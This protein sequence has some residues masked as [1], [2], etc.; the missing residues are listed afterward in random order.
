MKR[1]ISEAQ[2]DFLRELTLQ[3]ADVLTK[4]AYR[5]FGYQLHMREIA[6]EAVQDTYLKAVDDIETLMKHPNPIGWL[7][8]SLRYIL[9][10]IK[11][12]QVWKYEESRSIIRDTP[13]KRLYAA[14]DAF[15]EFDRYPRLKE[16]EEVVNTI[17]TPDEADTFYDHFLYGLTTEETAILEC[18][19]NDTVR[20]RISRIRK[21]LRKHYK[22]PCF[23]LLLLF[24]R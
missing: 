12:E 20:G 19:S 16:L 13:E 17:L 21:K 8:V 22:M 14:L 1:T 4:Y 11:R 7:K 18:V 2:A 3:S 5:F 15:D 23:L 6:D 24:Y 9:F 10:N